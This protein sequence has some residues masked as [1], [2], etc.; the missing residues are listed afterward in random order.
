MTEIIICG[1][2]AI[3][4]NRDGA[5][6]TTITIDATKMPK[7]GNGTARL[8][9]QVDE[10]KLDPKKYTHPRTVYE[11]GRSATKFEEGE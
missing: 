5:G 9:V 6:D 2:V 4:W 8:T 3:R 1:D 11:H 7:N 10:P